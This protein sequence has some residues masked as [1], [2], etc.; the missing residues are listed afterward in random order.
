[1]SDISDNELHSL[2]TNVYKPPKNFDI[3]ENERSFRFAWF[4][5][6]QWVCYSRWEDGAYCL[7]CVLFGYKVVGSSSLEN[8][9]MNMAN[10]SK[11]VQKTSECSSGDTQKESN[12]TY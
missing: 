6:F 11:N 3:P 8:L 1:M 7:P 4:Q 9:Y 10:G 2:M 5:E 12:T